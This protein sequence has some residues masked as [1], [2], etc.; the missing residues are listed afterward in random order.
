MEYRYYGCT[1][2]NP[3]QNVDHSTLLERPYKELEPKCLRKL[4][5]TYDVINSLTDNLKIISTVCFAVSQCHVPGCL[6]VLVE[7]LVVCSQ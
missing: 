4:P 7:S 6:S 3:S 1:W 2:Y 5:V